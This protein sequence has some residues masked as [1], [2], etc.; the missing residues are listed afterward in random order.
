[1]PPMAGGASEHWVSTGI[2]AMSSNVQSMSAASQ[3]QQPVRVARPG[4]SMRITRVPVDTCSS[5]TMRSPIQVW[6][7]RTSTVI[8]MIVPLAAMLMVSL[9]PVTRSLSGTGVP[10]MLQT[11]VSWAFAVL[12]STKRVRLSWSSLSLDGV[13]MGNRLLE[14]R[15]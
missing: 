12:T 13:R 8:S 3:P 4:R 9:A 2:V 5:S 7:I 6:L 14:F 11:W 15:E 10:G 1:M